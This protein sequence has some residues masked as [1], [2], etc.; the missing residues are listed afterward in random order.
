[1]RVRINEKNINTREYLDTLYRNPSYM[2]HGYDDARRRLQYIVDNL[3]EF[4]RHLDVGCA[5]GT[6]TKY[7]LEKYPDTVGYGMDISIEALKLAKLNCPEGSFISRIPK[8]MNLIHCGEVL[9]HLEHPEDL[10]KQMYESLDPKGLL[11]ITTPNELAGEYE[12]HLWK[13]DIQ[14][15]KDM[16]QD[17]KIIYENP[18]FFNDHLLYL[19]AQKL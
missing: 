11:V 14:G 16:L 13:W 6:F 10:I 12:E 4:L 8:G 1:M 3:G 15:V 9:E 18:R 19:E 17:F 5:D 7:Y 2:G